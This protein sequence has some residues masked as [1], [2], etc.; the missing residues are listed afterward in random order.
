MT[1][2]IQSIVS[3][4]LLG[5]LFGIIAMGMTLHWGMLRVINLAH[6]SLT[7]LAAYTTYQLS[8]TLQIDPILTLF[9]TVPMYFV[10]GAALQWF[11]D[12]FEIEGFVSLLV[13][14]GLFTIFESLMREI[15]TADFRDVPRELNPYRT[16]SFWVGE[17]SIRGPYLASFILAILLAIVTWYLLNHTYTGKAIRAIAQDRNMASAYGVDQKR[18]TLLL[19]GFIG[20]SSAISGVLIAILLTLSPGAATEYI[21]LIMA[22]VIIGGLGNT[23]GAF[24]AGIMIGVTQNV[25]ATIPALGPGYAPLVTFVILILVLLIRP[26]GLFNRGAGV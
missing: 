26:E 3:G 20:A 17:I 16:S 24:V 23:A 6:F 10:F 5:G 4:L 2:Y 8:V 14:F 1:T 18:I 15:W 25:V 12:R 11:F 13:T 21:G 22:V 9:V 7:F 19:G